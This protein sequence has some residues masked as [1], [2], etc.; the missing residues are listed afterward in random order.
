MIVTSFFS[1][2]RAWDLAAFA[3]SIDE[4]I[5]G[6]DVNLIWF[7]FWDF[8]VEEDVIPQ[9]NFVFEV[10]VER[11]ELNFFELKQSLS[12]FLDLCGIFIG[13]ADIYHVVG[14]SKGLNLDL[15]PFA[16]IALASSQFNIS[17]SFFDEVIFLDSSD[18]GVGFQF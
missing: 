2:T 1:A 13:T 7:I 14:I 4:Y 18:I 10:L 3:R 5:G 15:A 16:G 11:D 8:F 6:V 17:L 9:P 12:L